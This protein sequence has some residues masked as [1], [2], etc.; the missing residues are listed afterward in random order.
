[1]ESLPASADSSGQAGET[2]ALP[3]KSAPG[4]SAPHPVRAFRIEDNRFYI[5][6]NL[7]GLHRKVS[8]DAEAFYVGSKKLCVAHIDRISIL[9]VSCVPDSLLAT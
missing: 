5:A 1:M 2:P 8:G 6:Q 3:A 4:E 9:L 7:F